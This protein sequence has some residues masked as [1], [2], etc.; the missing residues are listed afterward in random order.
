M[1]FLI[2]GNLHEVVVKGL[3]TASRHEVGLGVVLQTFLVK[4]GLKMLQS[5]SIVE[6]VG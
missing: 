3:G 6:N 1:G 2:R 4:G 5:Q